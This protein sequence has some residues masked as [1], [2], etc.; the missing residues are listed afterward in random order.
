MAHKKQARTGKK[1]KQ[2]ADQ[3]VALAEYAGRALDAEVQFRVKSRPMPSDASGRHGERAT[4]A[5]MS[6]GP[7]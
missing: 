5:C 6:N 3:A 2:L 1:A 7:A 4:A